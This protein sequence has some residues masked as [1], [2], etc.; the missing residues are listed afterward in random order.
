MSAF[1]EWIKLKLPKEV[2]LVLS[3]VCPN[4][5]QMIFEELGSQADEDD[6]DLTEIAS[7]CFI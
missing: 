6:S 5:L 7:D 4:L 1:Y 2:L 3:D